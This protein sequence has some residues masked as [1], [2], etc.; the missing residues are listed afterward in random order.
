MRDALDDPEEKK[1]L[2]KTKE[3]GSKKNKLNM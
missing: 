3:K 1:C 2:T